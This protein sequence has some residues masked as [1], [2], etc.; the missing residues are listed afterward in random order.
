MIHLATAIA[1]VS[2]AVGRC[3]SNRMQA[4]TGMCMGIQTYY[5]ISV[6]DMSHSMN[7]V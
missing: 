3:E 5:K 1:P 6:T 7:I 2:G 4:Y